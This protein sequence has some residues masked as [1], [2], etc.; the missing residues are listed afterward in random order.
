M[1]NLIFQINVAAV[2]FTTAQVLPT[3]IV[4]LRD[5]FS[6]TSNTYLPNEAFS[7][8]NGTAPVVSEQIK[9]SPPVAAVKHGPGTP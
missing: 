1:V 2:L 5:S 3:G 4:A 7:P 9:F 6:R 8:R